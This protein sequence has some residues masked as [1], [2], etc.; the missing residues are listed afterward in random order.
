M[1][2][3]EIIKDSIKYPLSNIKTFLFFGL[4]ILLSDL[5]SI[6]GSSTNYGL[7][8]I[9]SILALILFFV[10]AGYQL[11][12]MEFSTADNNILPEINKWKDLLINGLKVSVVILFY[13]IPIVAIII[14]LIFILAISSISSGATSVDTN[15][16]KQFGIVSIIIILFCIWLLYIQYY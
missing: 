2:I 9:F 1:K 15:M 7:I 13:V 11:R 6:F 12:I 8:I 14:P 4:I 16:F 5:Y 10:R 3:G